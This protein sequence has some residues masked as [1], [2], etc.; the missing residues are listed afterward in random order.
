MS[1]AE[2]P[3]TD[4]Y[5]TDLRELIGLY[6]K[7]TAD[8]EGTLNQITT[9][10]DRL[11]SYENSMHS[12]IQ[13]ITQEVVPAAVTVSVRNELDK[14]LAT[15]NQSIRTLTE[16]YN[17]LQES[18]TEQVNVLNRKDEQLGEM[19]TEL[20]HN[21]EMQYKDLYAQIQNILSLVDIRIDAVKAE[22][23]S[24]IDKEIRKL[25]SQLESDINNLN[26]NLTQKIIDTRL[27]LLEDFNT[28]LDTEHNLN[29]QEFQRVWAEIDEIKEVNNINT[30]IN[31]WK[32]GCNFGGY[33]AYKWYQDA[34]VT[35]E[36]WSKADFSC[37]DWYVRGR[38]IFHWFDRRNLMISPVSGRLVSTQEVIQE[39][40]LA[41]SINGLSA[42]EYEM[43]KISADDY[44]K[45]KLTGDIYDW[46]GKGVL[47]SQ[48][49]PKT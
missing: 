13:R 6:R 48:K 46:A 11:T 4:L 36:E 15:I 2:F 35:A 27:E 40:C 19:I 33:D 30:I 38:E 1:Y 10:N 44:D 22:F 18:L 49:R 3:G 25:S 43:L 32:Y 39:L 28:A 41:L 7:L 29:N 45:L 17:H 24:T 37:I 21:T 16:N 14:E 34:W 23:N 5:E 8:Y 42:G 47:C 31:L 9:L 20:A 26:M 12:E